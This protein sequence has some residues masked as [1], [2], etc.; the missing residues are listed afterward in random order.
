MVRITPLS[1]H[2]VEPHMR[3]F[4]TLYIVCLYGKRKAHINWSTVIP[5][6][7]ST[8]YWNYLE[9]Y[10]PYAAGLSAVNAIGTQLRGLIKSALS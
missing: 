9:G 1:V 10:W 2:R 4:K 5:D 6:K 8:R 7:C 3:Y